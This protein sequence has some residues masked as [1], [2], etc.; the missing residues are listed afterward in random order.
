MK[1]IVAQRTCSWTS[2]FT[3]LRSEFTS[4]AVQGMHEHRLRGQT[5]QKHSSMLVS[6][7]KPDDIRQCTFLRQWWFHVAASSRTLLHP[8]FRLRTPSVAWHRHF[9]IQWIIVIAKTV[10]V[11]VCYF[12][13]WWRWSGCLW[14]TSSSRPRKRECNDGCKSLGHRTLLFIARSAIVL[15]WEKICKILLQVMLLRNSRSP[16][17][18]NR[19]QKSSTPLP[20]PYSEHTHTQPQV[21]NESISVK[22]RV[23]FTLLYGFGSKWVTWLAIQTNSYS[24]LLPIKMH[25]LTSNKDC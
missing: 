6:L 16:R 5:L 7:C 11:L 19:K 24:S 22:L 12:S 25:S 4:T 14:R 23:L 20:S 13:D 10:L 2:Q 3:S 21:L 9:V 8:R 18:M 1:L 15:L 17:Y